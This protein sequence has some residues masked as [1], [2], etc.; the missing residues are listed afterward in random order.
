MK[1]GL[2]P[3]KP[4]FFPSPVREGKVSTDLFNYIRRE[5]GTSDRWIKTDGAHFYEN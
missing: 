2:H 3:F 1:I 5:E 4:L